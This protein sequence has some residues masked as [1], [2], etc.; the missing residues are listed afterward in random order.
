MK[1]FVAACVAAALTLYMT[2]S[3]TAQQAEAERPPAVQHELVTEY[4]TNP[5]QYRAMIKQ[6]L[7]SHMGALGLILTYRAPHTENLPFHADALVTL[8]SIHASLYPE[9]S[10]T[11]QTRETIWSAPEEFAA[12]SERTAEIAAQLQSVVEQGTAIQSINRL[13]ALGESCE[14]CHARFRNAAD[15]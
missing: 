10:Q 6:A 1:A 2:S 12:A 11:Q 3:S 7:E 4:E 13:V 14:A 8:T 15:R 9:D 5:I